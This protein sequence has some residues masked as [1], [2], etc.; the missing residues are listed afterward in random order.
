MGRTLNTNLAR[1]TWGGMVSGSEGLWVS[2]GTGIY[3][4]SDLLRTV[5]S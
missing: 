2:M 5:I 1:G 3:R 4:V